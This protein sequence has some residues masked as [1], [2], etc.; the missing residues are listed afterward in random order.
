MKQ[1]IL[2]HHFFT[3]AGIRFVFF[4]CL[5]GISTPALKAQCFASSTV[6]GTTAVNDASI[7]SVDFDD[8][9]FCLAS[10]D[11]RARAT[12]VAVLF[13]GSTNYLKVTGF[14][15]NIPSYASICGVRVEIEKRA[16]GLA[17]GA[18]VRDNDVRLV[19][20][21]AVAGTDGGDDATDWPGTESWYTYG[22]TTDLW[23][24][25]LTPA[26]VNSPN[27]GVA[28][29]ASIRGLLAVF[30]SANIDNIRMTVYYNPILPV[31]LLS[32]HSSIK[33]NIARLEWE[34]A[35]EGDNESIILQRAV[36]GT[37][38]WIDLATYPL[39]SSHQL[40]KYYYDD[41]LTKAGRY[42]YR[43]KMTGRENQVTYSAIKQ[44]S[45]YA[46]ETIIAYP[47]PAKDFIVVENLADTRSLAITTITRQQL[48]PPVEITGRNSVRINTSLLPK[49]VY[50]IGTGNTTLRFFKE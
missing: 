15:F 4:T 20:A 47:N 8:E 19:K 34:T 26:E 16:T 31:K 17:V 21:N 5:F 1:T 37:A 36:A 46:G 18:W 7:G 24:T 30:P 39:Q 14:G 48:H 38:E 35:D 9:A 43:L 10:D 25:T 23:G 40:K 45:Y 11:N 22:G 29:S 6:S 32:F 2:S 33:N 49:G 42:E 44:V 28:I 41:V 27:F 13:N 12:A 3:R 50:F